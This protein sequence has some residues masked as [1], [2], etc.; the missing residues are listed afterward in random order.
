MSSTPDTAVVI[1]TH[2]RER[3]LRRTLNSLASASVPGA[4]R[5]VLVVENGG[6]HGA[7]DVVEPF[8]GRLPVRYLL[9]DEGNKCKALNLALAQSATDLIYFLDDD[10]RIDEGAVVAYMEA[11]GRY[12]PGHH[13]AGPLEAEW[14]VE[15]PDWLKPYLPPSAVGWDKGDEE[16]YYDRPHFIGSNWAAFRADMLAVGG[17]SEHIGPG[18]PLGAIGDEM[19]LQ[20][21]LLDAGGRGVYLPSARAWHHVPRSD[22]DFDWARRRQQITGRTYG[23]LGWRPEEG[24][25]P[26]GLAG[27]LR[28]G[29][30]SL[31]VAVA[32]TIGWSEERRAYLEMTR[33]RTSGYLKG[34]RLARR[35]SLE[36]SPE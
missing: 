34:R 19:E 11:A 5:E 29:V 17:F 2:R 13:F 30:L 3:L 18:S 28:L 6:A 32:R 35:Q 12:G 36:L 26:E 24:P 20:Q 7:R 10:V 27:L 8:A 25:I 16:R 15:P 22:S 23:V 14:E 4:V 1:A 21:R 9:L 31:K 33:A